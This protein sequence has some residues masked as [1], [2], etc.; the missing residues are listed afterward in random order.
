MTTIASQQ[1]VDREEQYTLAKILGIWAAETIPAFILAWVVFP[2]LTP[3][4]VVAE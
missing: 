2:A 1:A 4:G 3:D